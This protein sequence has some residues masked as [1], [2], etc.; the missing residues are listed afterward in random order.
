MAHLLR[1]RF[2]VGEVVYRDKAHKGEH[3]PIIER[4]L[5]DAVQDKLAVGANTRILRMKASPAILTGRIFDHHGDRMTPTHTNKRGAR[6]R[7]YVSRTILQKRNGASSAVRASAPELEAKVIDALHGH[8]DGPKIGGDCPP[9]DDRQLIDDF[10]QRIVLKSDQIEIYLTNKARQRKAS[11]CS[12]AGS[13]VRASGFIR[14]PWVTATK[15]ATKGIIQCP[16]PAEPMNSDQ[17]DTVLKAIARA[18]SW[19]DEIMTGKSSIGEIA[20]R[21]GK[22]ERHVRLLAPLAFSGPALI[23]AI[24]DGT[25]PVVTVTGLAK[26]MPYSWRQQLPSTM[27]A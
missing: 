1:N 16:L 17:R 4:E 6:Y 18:R 24:I 21:E 7:Y 19:I 15:A 13:K 12:K 8:L 20:K 5:F 26:K 9:A 25:V 3:E 2:Y 27:S 14:V 22:V 23:S 11:R 10:V